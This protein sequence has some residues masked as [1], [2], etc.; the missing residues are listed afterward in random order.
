[1]RLAA[2]IV[3]L[4]AI[5]VGLVHV[6]R[7]ET[8]DRHQIQRLQLHRARLRRTL[9]DQ[10]V[11]LGYLTAPGQIRRRSQKMALDLN[12]EGWAGDG[13]AANE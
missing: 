6:R 1:M 5:A 4:A 12:E 8:I 10:Q 13:L 3:I 9:W 2:V 7:A 11:R